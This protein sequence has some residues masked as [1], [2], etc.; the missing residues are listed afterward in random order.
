MDVTCLRCGEPWSS[1]YIRFDAIH[2]AVD[3]GLPDV[4]ALAFTKD[5]ALTPNIRGCME[6][7]GWEFGSSVMVIKRCPC[8]PKGN[9]LDEE[10]ASAFEGVAELLG[11]DLDGFVG[12]MEDFVM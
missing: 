7:A 11:D 10:R 1:D 3:L 8:C 4:E 9:K 12:L 6:V 2:D 5:F